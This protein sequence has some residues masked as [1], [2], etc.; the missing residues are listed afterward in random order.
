MSFPT[1][2]FRVRGNE[3]DRNILGSIRRL[4][5]ND[6]FVDVSLVTS[7]DGNGSEVLS[8]HKVV[9]AACSNFF[10]KIFR[11][12]SMASVHP[13]SC[14]FLRGISYEDLAAILEFVYQGEVRVGADQLDS[15]MAAAEELQIKGLANRKNAQIAP[16]SYKMARR[17]NS[18]ED[19]V[20][21]AKKLRPTSPFE[22]VSGYLHKSIKAKELDT[23][24][25]DEHTTI[26]FESAV[27]SD[28]GEE[29]FTRE[30]EDLPEDDGVSLRDGEHG[31]SEPVNEFGELEKSSFNPSLYIKR[32]SYGGPIKAEC[33][34][35]NAK[36]VGPVT[37]KTHVIRTHGPAEF[38]ECNFCRKVIRSSFNFR[39]HVMRAHGLRG[40]KLIETYGRRVEREPSSEN[41][42]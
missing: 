1:E 37:A 27:K 40:R 42:S 31:S 28:P 5:D 35:C 22:A 8:C 29:I 26:E 13:N 19:L 39:N 38:Y 4:R 33:T 24:M 14:V 7:D 15:F 18:L 6:E 21:A 17:Q 34:L 30:S 12:Q 23:L 9:L 32:L 16:R 10:K 20:S 11:H 3:F 25:P 41:N 36:F 2:G